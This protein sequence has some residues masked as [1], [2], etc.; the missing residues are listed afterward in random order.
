MGWLTV[1]GAGCNIFSPQTSKST[2][3]VSST[4]SGTSCTIQANLDGGSN[5]TVGNGSYYTFPSVDPGSHTVN[6]SVSNGSGCGGPACEYQN[7][8]VNYSDTF[9]TSGGDVYVVKVAQ[10]AAC[11]NLV[12]SGP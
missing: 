1:L 4:L 10:G 12:V 11:Q 8:S 3:E 6:L 7:S 2:I 5:I 9:Q